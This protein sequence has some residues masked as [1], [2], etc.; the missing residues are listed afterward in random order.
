MANEE[1][2]AVS[3]PS[4][5]EREEAIRQQDAEFQLAQRSLK[6]RK[7]QSKLLREQT[8]ELKE[9][10]GI[11]KEFN[12]EQ[13]KLVQMN[14]ELK[15]KEAA[16]AESALNITRAK[17]EA[18][19]D[20]I[21]LNEENNA[22]MEAGMA[23]EEAQLKLMVQQYRSKKQVGK[24]NASERRA[25]KAA[26]QEAIAGAQKKLKQNKEELKQNKAN[27]VAHKALTADVHQQWVE[28]TK[29][30]EEQERYLRGSIAVRSRTQNILETTLGISDAWRQTLLGG[31]IEAEDPLG[32]ISDIMGSMLSPANILQSTFQKIWQTSVVLAKTWDKARTSLVKMSGVEGGIFKANEIYSSNTAM[33]QYGVTLEEA[34]GAHNEL[35]RGMAAFSLETDANQQILRRQAGLL[36]E[37]GVS[38]GTTAKV[39]NL[40]SMGLGQS[41]AEMKKTTLELHALSR[42]LKMP[43]DMIMEDFAA[44]SGELSKYGDQMIDVFEGLEKQAKNTGLAVNELL[45]IAQKFDTFETAGEAVGK[46]NALLGGPYLNSIEML[47]ATEDERIQLL[48]ESIKLSGQD[49]KNMSRFEKQAIMNAA[50][51]S[52]MATAMKLFGGTDA[53]FQKHAASQE[54]L[55][56]QAKAAQTAMDQLKMMF[57]QL[58]ISLH[59][60]LAPFLVLINGITKFLSLGDGWMG[61]IIGIT[62]SVLALGKA[63]RALQAA[64]VL[65]TG[66]LKGYQ[67]TVKTFTAAMA[68]KNAMTASGVIATRSV[69][70]AEQAAMMAERM[71]RKGQLYSIKVTG[72]DTV[73]TN[74]NTA[75]KKKNIVAMMWGTAMRWKDIASERIRTMWS[76]RSTLAEIAGTVA[77]GAGAIASGIAM[78]ANYALASSFG[79]LL[80]AMLPVAAVAAGLV[81]GFYL[82]RMMV[83]K[84]GKTIPAVVAMIIILAAA[85]WGVAIALGFATASTS[86]WAG[87]AGLAAIGIG[88][89]AAVAAGAPATGKAPSAQDGVPPQMKGAGIETMHDG[90]IVGAGKAPGTEVPAVLEAGE[91]VIPRGQQ[92][93]A[94]PTVVEGAAQQQLALQQADQTRALD[95][96]SGLLGDIKGFFERADAKPDREMV[97]DL[98]SGIE[99]RFKGLS[100][101]IWEKLDIR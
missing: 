84:F 94:A 17:L 29:V 56:A 47:Y 60:V 83:D 8:K 62:I 3:G 35:T 100:E 57:Q 27:T 10:Q 71:R 45:S 19:R 7:E 75:G 25:E 13:T 41:A 74:V 43:I 49:F 88:M 97:F 30:N 93:A 59:Y 73:V 64:W 1:D 58:A 61:R 12:I 38:A 33:L 79:T 37:L 5:S 39:F 85:L 28:A 52:D 81:G 11:Y 23:R 90:G 55:E 42:S 78:V 21:K 32:D 44:A 53:E 98:G 72:T 92:G 68:A 91:T 36:G 65:G 34:A 99:K 18:H 77:K 46:L 76:G 9:Q 80:L 40:L 89:G 15:R 14:L 6:N 31:L 22:V 2:P 54:K 48:R 70:T 4:K 50:G 87:V 63:W 86:M 95:G 67:A 96:M 16:E 82:G 20:E 51:I 101:N 24:L 26:L 66:I 69:A